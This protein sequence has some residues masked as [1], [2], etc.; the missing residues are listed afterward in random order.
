MPRV[1]SYPTERTVTRSHQW[2]G[3]G[4]SKQC[5]HAA[6]QTIIPRP[7]AIVMRAHWPNFEQLRMR[8][9]SR[10]ASAIHLF[11]SLV[12]LH[13]S[14]TRYWWAKIHKAPA[15]NYG[16]WPLFN[17]TPSRRHAAITWQKIEST[18]RQRILALRQNTS[19]DSRQISPTT[20][21]L[22][23]LSRDHERWFD[24]RPRKVA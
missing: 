12:R 1:N 7:A 4:L 17:S 9:S 22:L 15:T 16:L 6:T 3:D 23:L 20:T 19:S 11:E 8:S 10:A 13:S 18:M 14:R 2:V 21:M 5:R 24:T